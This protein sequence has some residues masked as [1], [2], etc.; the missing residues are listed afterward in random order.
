MTLIDRAITTYDQLFM[1]QI[2]VL[3]SRTHNEYITEYG[4][5]LHTKI[6]QE[7]IECRH[8]YLDPEGRLDSINTVFIVPQD[9]IVTRSVFLGITNELDEEMIS[10]GCYQQ[11]IPKDEYQHS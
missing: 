11:S 4:R 6:L 2:R 3:T 9:Q 10:G 5:P 7:H 1:I 8:S